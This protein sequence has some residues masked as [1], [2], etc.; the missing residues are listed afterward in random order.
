MTILD[1]ECVGYYD[2]EY[3][4]DGYDLML[5]SYLEDR[6]KVKIYEDDILKGYDGKIYKVIFAFMGGGFY[7][8]WYDK[9]KK[10]GGRENL[11]DYYNR[12]VHSGPSISVLPG[13]YEDP[14]QT[15]VK[16]IKDHTPEIIGN[17]F[18]NKKLWNK[19]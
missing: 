8:D 15:G 16:Y 7:L 1:I 2:D 14:N 4:K 9:K 5:C 18:E 11:S 13:G 6:N 17:K 3:F 12:V 19:I 10:I